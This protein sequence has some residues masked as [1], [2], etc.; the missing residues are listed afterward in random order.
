MVVINHHSIYVGIMFLGRCARYV[1][2]IGHHGLTVK[3][4]MHNLRKSD[5]NQNHK[6]IS[7]FKRSL[8]KKKGYRQKLCTFINHMDNHYNFA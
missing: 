7:S 6:Q 3:A 4:I 5:E 8:A 1:V 2:H